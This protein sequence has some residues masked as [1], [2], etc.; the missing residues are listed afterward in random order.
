MSLRPESQILVSLT[1]SESHFCRITWTCCPPGAPGAV[2]SLRYHVAAVCGRTRERLTPQPAAHPKWP[3]ANKPL[4]ICTGSEAL[5]FLPS[6]FG[7]VL[8]QSCGGPDTLQPFSCA[9]A[10]RLGTSISSLHLQPP[11]LA[12]CRGSLLLSKPSPRS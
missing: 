9:P 7:G 6:F 4:S 2:S 5:T 8:R 3:Y 1:A 11:G 10:S 12:D